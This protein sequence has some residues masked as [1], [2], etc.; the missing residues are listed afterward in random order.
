MKL[1]DKEVIEYKNG[2]NDIHYH[3]DEMSSVEEF[4]VLLKAIENEYG[5]IESIACTQQKKKSQITFYGEYEDIEDFVNRKKPNM[6]DYMDIVSFSCKER[7]IGFTLNKQKKELMVFS[8][9]NLLGPKKS[10][11]SKIKYYK[12][13]Y[14]NIIKF[15]EEKCAM[16][17]LNQETG[18]WISRSDLLSRFY[19]DGDYTEIEYSDGEQRHDLHR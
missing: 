14:G 4:L 9:E 15:D 12:D 1:I 3:F 18:K 16:Y 17:V 7:N 5:E 13:E 8:R 6:I 10:N 11:P 19:G 2:D